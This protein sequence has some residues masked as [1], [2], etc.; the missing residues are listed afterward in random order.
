MIAFPEDIRPSKDEIDMIFKQFD[1]EHPPAG[2]TFSVT[3]KPY[4]KRNLFSKT[5][6]LLKMIQGDTD[7]GDCYRVE[8]W[9]DTFWKFS[10]LSELN[11]ALAYFANVKHEKE[12]KTG[13]TLYHCQ[14][15]KDEQN[16]IF[17]MSDLVPF[18]RNAQSKFLIEQF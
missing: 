17:S 15:Y 18:L 10:S 13:Q 7:D 9:C 6:Y 14:V 4:I 3:Y 12:K 11:Q 16:T 8:E 2:L 5:F 1:H